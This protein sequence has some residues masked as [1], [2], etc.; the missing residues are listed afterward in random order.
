MKISTREQAEQLSSVMPCVD[1]NPAIRRHHAAIPHKLPA[2]LPKWRPLGSVELSHGQ[3]PSGKPPKGGGKWSLLS[4]DAGINLD[5]WPCKEQHRKELEKKR[6]N[7]NWKWKDF[8]KEMQGAMLLHDQKEAG[9]REWEISNHP[10]L[11]NL[12]LQD[13]I[14]VQNPA[15]DSLSS[16]AF[17]SIKFT[18]SEVLLSIDLSTQ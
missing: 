5:P 4:Y 8:K 1:T 11:R 16:I 2:T 6:K 9:E 14:H 12:T 10:K 18:N 13:P 15:W 3:Q 17:V 7:R